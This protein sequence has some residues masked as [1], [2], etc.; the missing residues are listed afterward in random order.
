MSF[1]AC[2]DDFTSLSKMLPLKPCS[3]N[4][5]ANARIPLCGR[6]GGGLSAHHGAW[7]GHLRAQYPAYA[8]A[9]QYRYRR[10]PLDSGSRQNHWRGRRLS[11]THRLRHHQA[12]RHTPQA[13]GCGAH[14]KSGLATAGRASRRACPRLRR[15]P[16]EREALTMATP[17]VVTIAIPSYNQG[18]FLQDA[19]TSIFDQDLPVEVFVADAGSTD[20]SVDV[21]KT[22]ESQL[23]GWRSH[24][25]RGQA[26]AI[27]K[28]IA[29]GRAPYVGW[30]TQ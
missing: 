4:G 6:Y 19:L 24:T 13:D 22:F 26:A 9:H 7:S 12:G 25:D 16:G 23:A 2:S 18:R 3:G 27:N 11:G 20:N 5:R 14:E 30:L 15:F 17:P 8:V 1:P 10:G 28:G 29:S 21:I